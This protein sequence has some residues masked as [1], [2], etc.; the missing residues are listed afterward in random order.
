MMDQIAKYALM[1]VLNAMTAVQ[2]LKHAITAK[3]NII[4]MV[5]TATIVNLHVMNA[6]MRLAIALYVNTNCI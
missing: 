6:R 1:L 2:A 5:A 3:I 4:I